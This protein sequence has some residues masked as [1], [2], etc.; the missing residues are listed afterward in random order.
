MQIKS[1]IFCGHRSPFGLVTLNSLL[2][3]SFHPELIILATKKRYDLF[4]QRLSQQA[5][6]AFS[7]SQLYPIAM[8]FLSIIPW[9]TVQFIFRKDRLDYFKNLHELN[10]VKTPIWYVDDV[11]D[12]R[13]IEQIR[14][15]S[16]DLFFCAAYPQIFS[17]NLIAVPKIGCVNFHP[18]LLPKFRG[19]HPHF[20]AIVK[21]EEKAGI[22][23]HFMTE[24]IDQGDV[25][26]Q[27]SFPIKQFTYTDLYER[28]IQETPL[29]IQKLVNFFIGKEGAVTPQDE[30]QATFF[31]N[32]KESDLRID[33][34]VKDSEEI[35]N[36]CRSEN[37]FCFFRGQKIGCL[38][39][40]QL[41]F[42]SD[43]ACTPGTIMDFSESGIVV[44][45]KNGFLN[46]QTIRIGKK[47]ISSFK[48]AQT[49][50]IKLGERLS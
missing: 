18:S 1:I 8:K 43:R 19:A 24:K 37:A 4:E 32:E 14:K 39:A 2:K 29:V 15:M 48:W 45:T 7:L 5:K 40:D 42:A 21:G 10:R 50:R 34:S 35:K 33:W 11:N 28:L 46:I 25:I 13:F 36:L 6:P 41:T 17:K 47:T 38:K 49:Q 22:T 30:S 20:W 12:T 44:R 26:V 27:T 23:A 3:S 9:R 31:K 16:P